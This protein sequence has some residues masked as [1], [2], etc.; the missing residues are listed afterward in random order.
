[1]EKKEE[2]EGVVACLG[3]GS[4]IWNPDT[5][6][7]RSAWFLDGPLVRAEFLRKSDDGRITLVLHESAALVPSLWAILDTDGPEEAST[8]LGNREG[9]PPRRH[10]DLIGLWQPGQEPPHSTIS[11]LPAWAQARKIKAVV[12]T[13]LARNFH[14]KDSERVATAE[15][16]ITYLSSLDSSARDRAKEYI[17]KAPLQVDTVIRRAIETT[18]GWKVIRNV[19]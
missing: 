7:M 18:L 5:L 17:R 14:G 16:V 11:D 10:K 15:E 1:M 19:G 6:P 2:R 3:W 12:W 8:A 9:I 4:L 13:K